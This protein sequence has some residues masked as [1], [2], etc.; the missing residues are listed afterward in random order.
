MPA[1]ASA[2]SSQ[3]DAAANVGRNVS[4]SGK[5]S[6]PDGVPVRAAGRERRAARAGEPQEA[7]LRVEQVEERREVDLVG[8]A[9]VQ[10]DE[11][12]LAGSTGRRPYTRWTI[13]LRSGVME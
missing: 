10:E 2:A 6:C 13:S 11:G 7:L 8:A 12:A 4:R 3:S 9:A 1:S 5:P